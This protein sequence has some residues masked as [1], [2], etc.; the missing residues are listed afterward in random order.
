MM[1]LPHMFW[2]GAVTTDEERR[3]QEKGKDQR[4][5]SADRRLRIQN[6]YRSRFNDRRR[7]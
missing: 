1:S 3:Q 2:S 5:I 4:K 7:R 6:N